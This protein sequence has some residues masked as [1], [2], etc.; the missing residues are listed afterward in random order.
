MAILGHLNV[1]I[2]PLSIWTR[3]F[4]NL[5]QMPQPYTLVYPTKKCPIEFNIPYQQL[6][7]QHHNK[8]NQDYRLKSTEKSLRQ[9]VVIF[10]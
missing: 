10:L 9:T 1:L 8:S 3:G 7:R 5:L 4:S 2:L 6:Q